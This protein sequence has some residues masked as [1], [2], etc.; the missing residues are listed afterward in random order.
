MGEKGAHRQIRLLQHTQ[1]PTHPPTYLD[2][3]DKGVLL[4]AQGLFVD[5]AGPAQHVLGE[6]LHRVDG[7][8]AAGQGQTFLWGVGG[9]VGD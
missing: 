1:P 9:W 8:A 6:V 3:L 7:E 2:V 5:L 4:V